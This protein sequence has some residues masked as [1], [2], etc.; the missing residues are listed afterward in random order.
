MNKELIMEEANKFQGDADCFIHA[1]MEN[2]KNCEV[3]LA[4][5]VLSILAGIER[6]CVNLASQDGTSFENVLKAVKEMHRVTTK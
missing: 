4:G 3:V 6:I 5:D 2:G 1:E